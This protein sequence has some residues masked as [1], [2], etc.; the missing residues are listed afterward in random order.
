MCRR[1]FRR[2]FRRVLR[3]APPFLARFVCSLGLLAWAR[4]APDTGAAGKEVWGLLAQHRAREALAILSHE[5]PPR[6]RPDELAAL[7]TR[8]ALATDDDSRLRALA[9][10]LAALAEGND[11]V[12]AAAS[13]LT[14]R[15]EQIHRAEPDYARAAR[16]F[17][18]TATRFPQSAWGQLSLV[19]LAVLQL[20]V[21]P[22]R[23]PESRVA[24]ARA[25]LPRVTIRELRRDLH[26]V[27]GRAAVEFGQPL[28]DA[29]AD[30]RAAEEAG[31]LAQAV[32]AE[33]QLQIGV[34][35]R[36][37]GE[38]E[39]AARYLERFVANNAADPR[40]YTARQELAAVLNPAGAD[41]P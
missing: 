40:A 30:L 29:L 31:G 36:R 12:A 18:A 28:R 27:I 39:Q 14:A 33:L 41:T 35:S 37:V 24:A 22:G 38:P 23:S 7:V 9:L 11:D 2:K 32:R 1:F 17:E 3:A 6:T 25:L 16:L 8:L 20:Y 34:L 19:K 4:G 10:E 26:L 5:S 13:Y 15:I 21:L